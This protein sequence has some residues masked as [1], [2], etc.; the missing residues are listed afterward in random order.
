MRLHLCLVPLCTGTWADVWQRQTP[1]CMPSDPCFPTCTLSAHL[2]DPS[3]S[4][5]QSFISSSSLPMNPGRLSFTQSDSQSDHLAARA[6]SFAENSYELGVGATCCLPASRA[7]TDVIA[8]CRCIATTYVYSCPLARCS[9]C[10]SLA[11]VTLSCQHDYTSALW[12]L[13]N[14]CVFNVLSV[15]FASCVAT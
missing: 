7:R 11:L 9:C 8:T 13:A 6:D 10:T 15:A 14:C 12:L 4:L 2:C 3:A 5:P 1:V